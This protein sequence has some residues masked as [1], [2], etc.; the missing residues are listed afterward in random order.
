MPGYYEGELVIINVVFVEP[1]PDTGNPLLPTA[2]LSIPDAEEIIQAIRPK[3]AIIT[4]F[5]HQMWQLDPQNTAR[6]MTERTGFRV[7]AASDGMQFSLSEPD[8]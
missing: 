4:H 6:M 2:H 8:A 5:G 1:R 7:I 3:T